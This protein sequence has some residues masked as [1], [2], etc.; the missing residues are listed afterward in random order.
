MMTFSCA[1]FCVRKLKPQG[2]DVIEASSSKIAVELLAKQPAV[3]ILD[4]GELSLPG[5]FAFTND[6]RVE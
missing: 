1:N 2:Y 6:P 3:I 4:P 5:A